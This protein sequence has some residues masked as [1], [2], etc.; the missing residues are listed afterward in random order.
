MSVVGIICEYNPFHRGH[1]YQISLIREMLGDDTVILSL[2]SGST[3]QRGEIA[4]ASKYNRAAA[5]VTYGSDLVLELPYP[6]SSCVAEQ[7][8]DGAVSI[9][10]SLGVVDYLVFGSESSDIDLLK[11]HAKQR[12]SAEFHALLQSKRSECANVS[13]PRLVET[14]YN[15][16]YG[17][18]FPQRPNDILAVFYLMAIE[19]Y[20]ANIQPLCHKRLDGASATLG[21][22]K[23]N[24]GDLSEIPEKAREYFSAQRAELRNCERTVLYTLGNHPDKYLRDI[25][26]ESRSLDD[27][28]CG[29][30]QKNYTNARTR[31]DVLHAMLGYCE[32]DFETPKFTS[33]LA[34]NQKGA[35]L[36][37][38]IKHTGNITVITKPSDYKTI[39]EIQ[40]QFELNLRA[41]ELFSLCSRE[42]MSRAWSLRK[43]PFVKK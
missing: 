24:N 22:E 26:K 32:S 37:K 3:V 18:N 8:A 38:K 20:N 15:R 39:H 41:D 36:L 16:L 9:L 42:I 14:C 6:Y 17:E 33:V 35:E 7:F 10:S 29:L 4:V 34:M 5:A 28:Y 21:R 13:F 31:R 11:R 2:M 30:A 23:M 27:L 40:H 12:Q 43:S 1:A 25:A 19:K